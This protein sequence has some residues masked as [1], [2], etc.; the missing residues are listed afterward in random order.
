M[1]FSG[2][3]E[4]DQAWYWL[5]TTDILKQKAAVEFCYLPKKP[6]CK[7]PLSYYKL[8]ALALMQNHWLASSSSSNILGQ[9]FLEAK[10]TSHSVVFRKNSDH[11]FHH[12]YF[13]VKFQVS[14][15]AA[16]GQQHPPFDVAVDHQSQ[17]AFTCS[18]ATMET[19]RHVKPAQSQ[20]Q[21]AVRINDI[22]NPYSCLLKNANFLIKKNHWLNNIL[23]H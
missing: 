16:P 14:F 19:P 21:I 4:K 5:T 18:K 15:E 17:P 7:M 12:K 2:G 11:K 23:Y 13:P 20:W 6:Q 10:R 22:I 8:Q 3:T 9:Y 1:S